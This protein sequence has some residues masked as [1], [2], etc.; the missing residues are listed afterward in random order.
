[1]RQHWLA[2]DYSC[3]RNIYIMPSR[4]ANYWGIS[5][6]GHIRTRLGHIRTRL[7]GYAQNDWRGKIVNFHAHAVYGSAMHLCNDNINETH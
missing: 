5:A 2:D 3:R 7:S 6:L 4:Y 1:M